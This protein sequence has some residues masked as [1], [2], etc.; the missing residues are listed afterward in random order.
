VITLTA[1]SNREIQSR[2][3][4]PLTDRSYVGQCADVKS[5]VHNI[6]TGLRPRCYPQ[7]RRYGATKASSNPT[8]DTRM[9]RVSCLRPD[10]RIWSEHIER[11]VKGS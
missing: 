5:N 11:Q 1:T 4:R 7:G 6:R 8:I 10:N 9:G 2:R 3:N